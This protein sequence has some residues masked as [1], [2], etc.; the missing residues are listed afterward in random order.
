MPADELKHLIRR[1]GKALK[2]ARALQNR[3]CLAGL[4][5]L[6]ALLWQATI[7][8]ARFG[9]DWTGLYYA[10]D[11][12]SLPPELASRTY[13][14]AG[15]NGY[16][17]QFYRLAALDPLDLK[18]YSQYFDSPSYRRRRIG[19]PALAWLLGFGQSRLIDYS[20][21]AVIH[22]LIAAGVGLL[23]RLAQSYGRH[24]AWGM[25]FLLYPATLSGVARLMPGLALGVSICGYLLWRQE[26]RPWAWALLAFGCLT[27]ELGLL[28]VAAAVG[29]ELWRRR[30][31][32]A[33]LWTSSVLP[34]FAWWASIPSSGEPGGGSGNYQWLGSHAFAG[35]FE[36]MAMP[37]HYTGFRPAEL[38]L[39][40]AD[41]AVMAGLAAA[42]VAALW[43][44][45]RNRG[46]DLEWL[47]LAAASLAIV[48]ANP[49]FLRDE[50]STA[51]AY[52]LLTGPLALMALKGGSG[53]LAVPLGLLSLRLALGMVGVL[54][55]KFFS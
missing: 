36:R 25:A 10:G 37:V 45:W 15:S 31:A 16:D 33:A 27:R 44:W 19:V 3:W 21:I 18:G 20:Y 51:R 4:A 17:A 6:L 39:Q 12:F 38:A 49:Y 52:S 5:V 28:L 23:S 7:V 30:W 42:A 2:L 9:G 46:G 14:H 55:V 41:V 1:D 34:A 8:H 54:A 35:F 26:R 24:Q 47:A 13:R 48:A 32:L 11:G 50:C 22:L 43:C 29:Q 53:W 40:A